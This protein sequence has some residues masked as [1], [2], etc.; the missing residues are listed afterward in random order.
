M[1]SMKTHMT[2]RTVKRASSMAH[3]VGTARTIRMLFLTMLL[4]ALAGSLHAQT[5]TATLSGVV[6]DPTGAVVPQVKITLKNNDRGTARTISTA[7]DG[8]YIFP[9]VEPGTYELRAECTGFSTEVKNG[10]VLTVGGSSQMDLTLKV[11]LVSEVITVKDVA[12]LI[13][14]SKA[15]I[16]NV[17]TEQAIEALPNT[18]RNFVDFVKL[19]SGVAPGGENTSEGEFEELDPGLHE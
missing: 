4:G 3:R 16:S 11:G 15:E 2:N 9:S 12:P 18:G 8:R 1:D 7:S 5:T 13:E 19:S 6:R 10:I 17:I 14:T